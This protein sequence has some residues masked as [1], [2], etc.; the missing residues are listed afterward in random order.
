MNKKQDRTLDWLPEPADIGVRYLA[1]RDLVDAAPAERSAARTRAHR[2]GP[3][4]RVLDQMETA[5]Y[6]PEAVPPSSRSTG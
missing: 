6:W 3:I 1:L 2:E 5:G 4:A